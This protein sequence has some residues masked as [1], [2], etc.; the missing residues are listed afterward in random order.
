MDMNFGMRPENRAL[1][2]R[3]AAMIRDEVM[4]LE[5]E[6]H[7]EIG[8]EDRWAYTARQSEIL[9]GLKAAEIQIKQ[10]EAVA[11]AFAIL[12]EDQWREVRLKESHAAQ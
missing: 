5:A 4:P 3:V 7:A 8:K 10:R 6:Y 2:D 1:L 12:E 9:E 11:A